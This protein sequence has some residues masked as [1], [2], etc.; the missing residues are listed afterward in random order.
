MPV[1]FWLEQLVLLVAHQIQLISISDIP[2][3]RPLSRN[4]RFPVNWKKLH[5]EIS[6]ILASARPVEVLEENYF[7]TQLSYMLWEK[8]LNMMLY[9]KTAW[10]RE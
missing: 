4:Y 3:D 9:Q 10:Y 1:L 2:L 6:S 7:V 8:S 5:W